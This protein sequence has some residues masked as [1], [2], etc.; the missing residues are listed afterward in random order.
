MGTDIHIAVEAYDGT[1]WVS[2][3]KFKNDDG[4]MYPESEVYDGQNYN[5]FA[6]LA[7]VRNGY[8]FAGVKTSDGFN[9]ISTPKGIPE[10]ASPEVSAWMANYDHTPSWL[11]VAEIMA[12]D[13]TQVTTLTGVVD[14]AEWAR[15]K[16]A[17]EPESWSGGISGPDI[18]VHDPAMA[19][20]AWVAAGSPNLW[21]IVHHR[22]GSEELVQRKLGPG[23]HYFR[24]S[25]DKPYHVCC[26][27]F[28]G[29][30][31]PQLWRLGKPEH[32]RICF[33]FDS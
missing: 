2:K 30:T 26:E 33:F 31:L 18:V 15:W 3:T 25:W 19:E 10:D 7:N 29:S 32:V 17:G 23:R 12:F 20:E 1:A 8:G 21:D 11:T 6:I 22:E 14:L 9:F 13:W 4:Y 5:L 16:A 27:E 28:L 24:V